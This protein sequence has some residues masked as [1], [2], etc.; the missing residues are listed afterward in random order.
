MV[1]AA[2]DAIADPQGNA[3][4]HLN[5][6]GVKAAV[7]H[8]IRMMEDWTKWER[9]DASFAKKGVTSKET[10]PIWRAPAEVVDSKIAEEITE[11]VAEIFAEVTA[12]QEAGHPQEESKGREETT[13]HPAR[14]HA[15]ETILRAQD[16]LVASPQGKTV[17]EMR[18][19]TSQ[20][21]ID[22]L[23]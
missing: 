16:P 6:D 23:N 5:S 12:T 4:D 10:A 22:T 18:V 17:T 3:V 14:L 2:T 13:L 11:V 15:E 19:K 7:V 21:N 8:V 20:R 1:V 9:V